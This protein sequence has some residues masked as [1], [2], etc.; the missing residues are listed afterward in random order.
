MS[1]EQFSA[2]GALKEF[3]Y[4]HCLMDITPQQAAV[5]QRIIGQGFQIV[6][7]PMYESYI[8]VRKGNC[9]ALLAPQASGGLSIYGQPAYLIGGNFGVKMF[10]P[11]GHYFVSKKEKLAATPERTRELEEFSAELADALLPTA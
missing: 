6:A 7:F 9:A 4:S 5:L 10:E 11:D 3:C 2:S 1:I 8:G